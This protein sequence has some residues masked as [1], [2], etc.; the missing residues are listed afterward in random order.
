M[1]KMNSPF[2]IAVLLLGFIASIPAVAQELPL[3]PLPEDIAAAFDETLV[4]IEE[5]RADVAVLDARVAQGEG[6]MAEVMAARRD[7]HW[8]AMVK[9]TVE[10]ARKVAEQRDMNRD[11]SAYWDPMIE[12]LSRL[13]DEIREAIDRIGTET[14]VPS[15]DLEL[16]EFVIA[17]QKLFAA[18]AQQHHLFETVVAY[19][20]AADDFG[21]DA[22]AEREFIV[23]EIGD[24]AANVSGFLLV[25]QQDLDML[26][27]A[28]VTL[29]DDAELV[30]WQNTA[31]TR[32]TMTADALQKAVDLMTALGLETR[33]Y[34]QQLLTATG[35]I[36]ADV[37][38]VGIV[39][40]LMSDWT[41]AASQTFASEGPRL[42]FRGLLIVLILYVFF[43]LGKLVQR[44][45]DRA[46]SSK[47]VNLSTLLHSMITS[48]ARNVVILIGL[49][50][51]ISQL[52][53]SLGP[54]LA[55]LGIAG[56]IIGFALQDTLSNFASGMMILMYRPF[57]VGDL[58]D[59]GGVN[60]KVSHMSLVN[61]TFMTLDNQRLIVPNNLIWQSVITNVTSQRVRRIDLMFGISYDDDIDKAEAILKDIVESHEAT[62]DKPEAMIHL[63][64]LGDSSVNF[65][66]RPWVKTDD[67]WDTYWDITKA[68]K[69]RFDEEG[70][71]IP[72]P[73]R[74]IH[75]I[76]KA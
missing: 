74:D 5:Q 72:Y 12:E 52:G 58:V 69:K 71:S 35:E 14:L 1:I 59:A 33:I 41:A 4:E 64:E 26:R 49:M 68:V 43:Q 66:V 38:D 39:A 31:R 11:V 25:A 8:T 15:S 57:D 46:L 54:L 45:V 7:I 65:I 30:A 67:Y 18:V 36:T 9:K 70:I 2:S 42:V 51:A 22:T 76:E 19:V 47:R 10:L 3:E 37:F 17:D 29:P 27:A 16:K 61:T 34:R 75:I 53:I 55:G 23:A 24:H 63:H 56:F 62:L 20:E 48:V 73:Q 60:G 40:G 28:S 44:G 13:P 21:L 32:I 50:L 6:M